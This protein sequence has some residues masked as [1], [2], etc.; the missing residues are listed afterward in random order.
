MDKTPFLSIVI[1]AYN[2]MFRLPKTLCEILDFVDQQSYQSEILIIDDGSTDDTVSVAREIAN[3]HSNV[4]V[5]QNDHRGKGY[6]VRTG[7]FSATG[8]HLL[9]SDADLAVPIEEFN[10]FL[11]HLDA[12]FDVVIASREGQGAQR[13]GEPVYRHIMGRVF[14]LIIRSVTLDGF[15]DTQCGF[16][17]FKRDV[18]HDL[19]SHV[20]LYGEKAGNLKDPAVTGFDVEVLFLAIKRGYKVKEVPVNWIYGTETKVNPMKDT[21]RNLLDVL[22]VRWNDSTGRYDIRS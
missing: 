6:A 15:K 14:N 13:I 3:Q 9:F 19:F 12:G 8:R 22:R 17:A 1:P 21:L 18:A 10:K 2:E 16:K 5:I 4:T 7:I 11:P 20:L